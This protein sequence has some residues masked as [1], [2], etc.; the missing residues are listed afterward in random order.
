ML[1]NRGAEKWIG[2]VSV[3]SVLCCG[4]VNCSS[5]N[6]RIKTD[7]EI[8]DMTLIISNELEGDTSQEEQITIREI[9]YSLNRNHQI[10]TFVTRVSGMGISIDSDSF[11]YDDT[12]L[13][14][15]PAIFNSGDHLYVRNNKE[16][17]DLIFNGT[18]VFHSG[19]CIDYVRAGDF[20][21]ICSESDVGQSITRIYMFDSSSREVECL[22]RLENEYI[23]DAC[24]CNGDVF[25]VITTHY[26]QSGDKLYSC[27]CI[28]G[29]S[30]TVEKVIDGKASTLAFPIQYID[31]NALSFP[32]IDAYEISDNDRYLYN[33]LR[34][35]KGGNE[36]DSQGND[37]RGRIS[38]SES[39]RLRGL[40]E[41]YRKTNDKELGDRIRSVI[42]GIIEAQNRCIFSELVINEWNPEFLWSSKAYSKEN[43]PICILVDE[44][45]I[46]SAL[47]FACNEGVVNDNQHEEIIKIAVQTFEY[48]EQWYKDGHYYLPY[49]FPMDYDGIAVPWNYQNSFA[50][51]CLGLFV[52]TGDE[53][54][55]NR[56][57]ELIEAFQSEWIREGNRIY[58]HYW[59]Q[60]F[61]GGWDDSAICMNTPT[62]D[63]EEDVLFEDVSHAGIS[64]RLLC[65]YYEVVPQG[66]VGYDDIRKIENNMKSFCFD[67]G[68]SRFI[69]GDDNYAP[70]A[71][72]YWISPYFSYLENENFEEYVCQG[73][74]HS[75]P[76]WDSQESLFAYSRL[77]DPDINGG[78]IVIRRISTKF[79]NPEEV[80]RHELN[81]NMLEDYISKNY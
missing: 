66:I 16:G 2:V 8:S 44:S 42:D 48:Y 57:D 70:R 68:F 17:Y 40:I 80:S 7:T 21:A 11:Y 34:I 71:W 74:L 76:E 5:Y 13:R 20:K 28:D 43:V 32:V 1:G 10:S 59:P 79:G 78:Q 15:S 60:S 31:N 30:G 24:R 81:R 75:F 6:E 29:N 36:A 39:A 37:F 64:I 49:G 12:A 63:A 18:S 56:C 65:R 53:K 58:W 25:G 3:V 62:K 4:C 45:E 72:H 51:V 77:F 50:E 47:L 69:S 23:E 54:Y 27:Y 33:A 26:N 19:A 73:Y 46:L 55:L 35:M 14:Y 9:A 52:E 61:Y 22:L 67:D 41:L 38:W